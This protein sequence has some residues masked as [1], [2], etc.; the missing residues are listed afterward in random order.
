MKKK[1]SWFCIEVTKAQICRSARCAGVRGLAG[2]FKKR[3]LSIQPR[4]RI[5]VACCGRRRPAAIEK[6]KQVQKL[7]IFGSGKTAAVIAY[8][9][10]VNRTSLFVTSNRRFARSISSS[11]MSRCSASTI[12]SSITRRQ[13]RLQI[14][15]LSR[16]GG[17]HDERL[18]PPAPILEPGSAFP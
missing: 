9:D 4:S 1:S 11:S 7:S 15:C 14:G 18:A 17:R 5:W 10:F 3:L 2:S 8:A 12:S 13:F 16:A 6:L